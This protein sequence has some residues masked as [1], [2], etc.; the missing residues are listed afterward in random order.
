MSKDRKARTTD[1]HGRGWRT[2]ICQG[3]VLLV[4][5][6]GNRK[7]SRSL[8]GDHPAY[9]MSSDDRMKTDHVL[10]VIPLF[11]SPSK[12]T[13]AKDVEI[14]PMECRGLRRLEYAQIMNM[15]KISR[16]QIVRRIGRVKN[17]A[18]HKELLTSIWGQVGD[19]NE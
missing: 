4:H 6:G 8:S 9:V 1:K 19:R 18:V 14:G 7:G 2:G 12:D 13:A 15:Q 10:M 11:R 17:E 16:Y 5:F 3:D